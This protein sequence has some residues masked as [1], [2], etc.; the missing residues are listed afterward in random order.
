M[1]RG[2]EYKKKRE[3]KKKKRKRR[4]EGAEAFLVWGEGQK[5]ILEGSLDVRTGQ[6]R[7]TEK[8]RAKPKCTRRV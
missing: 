6:E 2:G 7:F 3:K 4:R 8:R 5:R 1:L